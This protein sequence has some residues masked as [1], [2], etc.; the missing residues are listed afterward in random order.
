MKSKAQEKLYYLK[1]SVFH[2][3][4]AFYEIRFRGK[5]SNLL[6]V[7]ILVLFG[8]LMCV[9]YQYTGFII[10]ENQLASMNS[11]SIFC[12]WMLGFILFIVGNWSITTLLNG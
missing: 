8:L 3:F 6:S 12:T 4:D 9:S 11:I 7:L 5:G 10:N 2:P 1:Y